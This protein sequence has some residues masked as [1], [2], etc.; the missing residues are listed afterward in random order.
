MRVAL[1][2]AELVYLR[3]VRTDVSSAAV[4]AAELGE[5]WL[6]HGHQQVGQGWPDLALGLDPSALDEAAWPALEMTALDLIA[7][8]PVP[9]ASAAVVG[10]SGVLAERGD[11]GLEYRLASVTKPLVARAA[12]VAVEEGVL[13]LDTL[14]P[15][16]FDGPPPARPCVRTVGAVR[17]GGRRTGREAAVFN[18]GF[19]VLAESVERAFRHRVRELPE[20]GGLRAAGYGF[21]EAGRRRGDGRV[22]RRVDG[23]R[24]G[25][26]RATC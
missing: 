11:V 5:A 16:G 20:R 25:A 12:Q 2:V 10:P 6:A 21:V 19:A 1:R 17:R 7:D 13:D 9:V 24:S 22:R 8:W 18:Y 26:S 3:L 4:K 23:G 15:A 14:P